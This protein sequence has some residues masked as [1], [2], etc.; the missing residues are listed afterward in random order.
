MIKDW[1]ELL[2]LLWAN[3]VSTITLVIAVKEKTA[4]KRRKSEQ[5]RSRKR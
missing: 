5:K 4:P 2:F 3:V 1:L